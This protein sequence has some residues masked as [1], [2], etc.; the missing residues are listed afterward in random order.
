VEDKKISKLI[1]DIKISLDKIRAKQSKLYDEEEKLSKELEKLE[2]EKQ[3]AINF[4][5]WKV[6][7][8]KYYHVWFFTVP[9]QDKFK[10]CC[11]VHILKVKKNLLR[12]EYINYEEKCMYITI[13]EFN[14]IHERGYKEWT[15]ISKKEYEKIISSTKD[16]ER[17]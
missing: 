17:I 2:Y 8:G 15:E 10:K 7:E 16:L 13:S 3:E 12:Y 14:H 1:E 5:T 4:K 9:E 11:Y 6:M